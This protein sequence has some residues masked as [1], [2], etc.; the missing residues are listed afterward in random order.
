MKNQ[1]YVTDWS[2]NGT[3]DL[4]IV[5]DGLIVACIE[6]ATFGIDVNKGTKVLVACEHGYLMPY[7]KDYNVE[8]EAVACRISLDALKR[9]LC[10]SSVDPKGEGLIER[11]RAVGVKV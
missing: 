9:K 6:E 11:L 3:N 10:V 1:L 2:P 7:R 8:T 4:L 5:R